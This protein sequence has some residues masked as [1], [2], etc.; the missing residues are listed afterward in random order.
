MNLELTNSLKIESEPRCLVVFL[1]KLHGQPGGRFAMNSRE[2][3]P[4][5]RGGKH[6]SSHGY[7]KVLVGEGHHLADSKGY[8]YEHKVIAE[9]VLGRRLKPGEIV[10]HKDGDKTNNSAEN[11]EALPSIAHHLFLHRGPNSQKARRPGE[12]NESRECA[13]GCGEAFSRYDRWGR[14]RKYVSGHNMPRSK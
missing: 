2:N 7:A 11:I 1:G 14:E 9:K 4:N 8:A 5:W 12:L 10:H 13:C 6:L 3:N